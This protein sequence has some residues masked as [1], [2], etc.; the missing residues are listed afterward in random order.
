[1]KREILLYG[2]SQSN[3]DILYF[4]GVFVPDPFFSFTM[5]GKKCAL[6]GSLEVGRLRSNSKLDRVFDLSSELKTLPDSERRDDISVLGAILKKNKIKNFYVP[7]NFPSYHL[8]RLR[9]NGFDLKVLDSE[10]FPSREVKSR[11]EIAQ[12]KRANS[13][14]EAAFEYSEEILRNSKI[15]RGILFWRGYVLTSEILRAEI[16]KLCLSLGADA[17]HTIVAAGNQACNPHEVG[18][19]AIPANSLIVIDIFPRLRDTGYFGDMTRTFLKGFP[20]EAQYRL[21]SAVLKAQSKAILAIKAGVSGSD[22]HSKVCEVFEGCGYKTECRRGVWGGFFHS[23]GHGLGLEVHESPSLGTREVK[24]KAGNVVT[25]EPGLYYRGLGGCRI[26]D[27]VAVEKSRA[28]LLSE[29][30]YRWILE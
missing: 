2:D 6:I 1:M 8:E 12:I 30:H 15:D 20:S 23:T 28:R 24:L 25:V 4:T 5:G 17:M 22:V 26:E 21:V 16:E 14:A 19:G 13:V 29:Y 18:H 3:A 10:I 9:A 27:N 7:K 11:A